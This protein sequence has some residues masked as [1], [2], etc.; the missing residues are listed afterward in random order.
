MIT[1]NFSTT[2][3]T[4][5][6]SAAEI[7]VNDFASN[8][9]A[10]FDA[11]TAW[12][13]IA[14]AYDENDASLGADSVGAM[15]FGQGQTGIIQQSITRAVSGNEV[16]IYW[17]MQGVDH[18]ASG[19]TGTPTLRTYVEW[20][21]FSG[22]LVGVR[23][24]NISNQDTGV[25]SYVATKPAGATQLRIIFER[26]TDLWA[27]TLYKLQ[28]L[29]V[30]ASGQ[31]PVLRAERPYQFSVLT[32]EGVA[33]ELDFASSFDPPITALEI[34]SSPANY[35]ATTRGSVLVLNPLDG[36]ALPQSA[37]EGLEDTLQVRGIRNGMQTFAVIQFFAYAQE[38]TPL[39]LKTTPPTILLEDGHAQVVGPVSYV[40]GGTE[41]YTCIVTQKPAWLDQGPNG[42]LAGIASGSGVQQSVVATVTDG[43]G[44]SVTVTVPITIGSIDRAAPQVITP[45]LAGNNLWGAI[46]LNQTGPTVVQLT[47]G[48][49]TAMG[50]IFEVGRD[51]DKPVIIMGPAT[52]EARIRNVVVLNRSFGIW[53]EKVVFERV[54]LTGIDNTNSLS[55]R[56]RPDMRSKTLISEIDHFP[57]PPSFNRWTNCLSRGF[58][59]D[60]T[61]ETE[62]GSNG[63]A[64][65]WFTREG[66][67]GEPIYA[68]TGTLPTTGR[69]ATTAYGAGFNLQGFGIIQDTHVEGSVFPFSLAGPCVGL[70]NT[71]ANQTRTDQLRFEQ[72]FDCVVHGHRVGDRATDVP[73]LNS[74]QSEHQDMM[75]SI[76]N[77]GRSVGHRVWVKDLFMNGMQQPGV[78]GIQLNM[79]SAGSYD[80]Q[81]PPNLWAVDWLIEDSLFVVTLVN[82]L[83]AP[84]FLGEIRRC[85]FLP[86]PTLSNPLTGLST[87][88]IRLQEASSAIMSDSLLSDFALDGA[89]R[90]P[91]T[92]V[93]NLVLEENASIVPTLLPNIYTA[94]TFND[95]RLG[96]ASEARFYRD[97]AIAPQG[98]SWLSG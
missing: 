36:I 69:W 64:D 58:V 59:T 53:F 71:S 18:A 97:P 40:A 62:I 34:V 85:A 94:P 50:N 75:Q 56:S 82:A 98:P 57:I 38:A 70:F 45:A 72:A 42:L 35:R 25:N 73:F 95:P 16:E 27:L 96:V 92:L 52:G 48:I 30:T 54:D 88:K 37:A 68:S 78:Q 17:L 8:R 76:A 66:E 80:D 19:A 9:S 22:D 13:H 55:D 28:I 47:D 60:L 86:D 3:R 84:G 65:V 63:D 90:N 29:D 14:Q 33:T 61:N 1:L 24:A 26:R 83:N 10:D 77:S 79:G 5:G 87:N 93:G 20:L 21:N 6:A 81:D 12:S 46:S 23:S 44:Q 67:N 43:Q 51:H 89:P 2:V 39:R 11:P 91:W 74:K 7:Y 49:Y 41:P 4:P 31:T 15:Y 32:S